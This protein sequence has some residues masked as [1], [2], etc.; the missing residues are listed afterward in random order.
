VGLHIDSMLDGSVQRAERERERERERLCSQIGLATNFPILNC[1]KHGN[2]YVAVS[3]D[4]TGLPL[5][6]QMYGKH[7]TGYHSDKHSY[8][9]TA[10]S[11]FV[12]VRKP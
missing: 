7:C 11:L 4:N 9:N 1:K 12:T 3:A 5:I 10:V 2:Q 6:N 8:F